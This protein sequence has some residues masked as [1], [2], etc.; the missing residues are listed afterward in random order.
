M[1]GDDTTEAWPEP[2]EPDTD[3]TQEEI[4]RDRRIRAN[5]RMLRNEPMHYAGLM[6]GRYNTH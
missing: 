4:D 6:E 3:P 5:D 1:I 2:P